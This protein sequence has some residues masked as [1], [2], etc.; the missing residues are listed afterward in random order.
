MQTDFDEK[1]KI[2]QQ[3]LFVTFFNLFSTFLRHTMGCCCAK[4]VPPSDSRIVGTWVNDPRSLQLQVEYGA[5]YRVKNGFS[6]RHRAR[7]PHDLEMGVRL[8]I[9]PDGYLHFVEITNHGALSL[10]RSYLVDLPVTSWDG[11]VMEC[12]G[13]RGC[14]CCCNVKFEYRFTST[15]DSTELVLS[16]NGKEYSLSKVN[17][18][19]KYN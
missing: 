17:Q 10:V 8:I 13:C 15:R 18:K 19:E 5:P 14:G 16:R 11:G 2:N 4:Q 1:P 12:H 6:S 9:D 3:D 7:L